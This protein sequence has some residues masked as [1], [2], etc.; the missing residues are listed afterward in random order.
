MS[1]RSISSHAACAVYVLLLFLFLVLIY[2]LFL[3]SLAMVMHLLPLR[4][5]FVISYTS[6]MF[7]K[8]HLANTSLTFL[9]PG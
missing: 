4:Q 7:A 5:M 3:L 6:G 8:P 2:F 9:V 1:P